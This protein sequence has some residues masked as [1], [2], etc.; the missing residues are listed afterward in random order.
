MTAPPVIAPKA[1]DGVIEWIANLLLRLIRWRV[2]GTVPPVPKAV[3]IVAPHTSN[4]ELPLGLIC[5]FASGMLRYWPYGFMMKHTVFRWP[6]AGLMRQI[7]GLAVDRTRPQEIVPH[8]AAELRG[9]E[10]FLLAITPEGT[11]KRTRRWKSGFYHIA[12]AARVPIIPVS[13]DYARR[14]VR[15]GDPI[16]PTGDLERDLAVIRHFYDGVKAKR[17]DKVG[18]IRFQDDVGDAQMSTR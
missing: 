14:E 15:I 3:V 16:Q 11:R 4:W 18:E 9:R 17:P 1:P 2:V 8:M 10:R 6:L 13:F 7:G 12:S 5:G